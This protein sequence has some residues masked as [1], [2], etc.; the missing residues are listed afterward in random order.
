MIDHWVQP[1]YTQAAFGLPTSHLLNVKIP[2]FP[3]YVIN[4]Y[5]CVKTRTW[6]QIIY[7]RHYIGQQ[8]IYITTN[9][10]N[11]EPLEEFPMPHQS[12]LINTHEVITLKFV[13]H[14]LFTT[15]HK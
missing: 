7:G 4:R 3:I 8:I 11:L 12:V 5:F 9:Y 6:C 13:K 2:Y 10:N 1:Y 15:K 14:S